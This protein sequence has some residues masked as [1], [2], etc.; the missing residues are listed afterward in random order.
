MPQRKSVS[1]DLLDQKFSRLIR[2]R[3]LWTCQRCKTLHPG[4]S[5]QRGARGLDCSHLVGR[6]NR[7]LRWHPLNAVAHCTA[8][9]FRLGANPAEFDAWTRQH[10]GDARYVQL[11]ALKGVKVRWC[12]SDKM[13]LRGEMNFELR[14]LVRS[15]GGEFEYF[16]LRFPTV[17]RLIFEAIERQT[18]RTLAKKTQGV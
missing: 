9:H 13:E 14:R 2:G 15:E 10:L 16:D 5:V 3:D 1:L 11:H 7:A 12:T 4:G 8:C 6:A 18:R 17:D